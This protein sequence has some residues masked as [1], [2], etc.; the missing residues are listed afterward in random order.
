[1]W[2][3]S[4]PAVR[5]GTSRDDGRHRR[6]S[7][8]ETLQRMLSMTTTNSGDGARQ[9][10][11]RCTAALLLAVVACAADIATAQDNPSIRH[12]CRRSPTLRTPPRRPRSCS[13]AR[14]RPRELKR[15][16]RLLLPRLPAGEV[17]MPING[18]TWQVMR[19]S[20][21]PTGATRASCS[22]WRTWPIRRRRPAGVDCWWATCAA[23][24]WSDAHRPRQ[25]PLGLDADIWLTSMPTAS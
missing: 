11:E 4:I 25:R 12:R 7:R 1:M 10:L 14:P 21:N 18:R 5:T 16:P 19:L 24:R 3:W 6:R 22:S 9:N 8:R 15:A 2:G 20:R 13:G 23:A 17:A